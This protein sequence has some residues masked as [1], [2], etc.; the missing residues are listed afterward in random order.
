MGKS[1][2]LR[3]GPILAGKNASESRWWY[4]RAWGF[5]AYQL[6]SFPRHSISLKDPLCLC[7]SSSRSSLVGQLVKNPPAVQETP[8]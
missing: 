2:F 5:L 8:V 1:I 4:P 6:G 3:L 7:R